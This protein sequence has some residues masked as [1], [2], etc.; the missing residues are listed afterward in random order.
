MTLK[1]KVLSVVAAFALVLGASVPAASALTTSELIDLLVSLGIIP[2]DQA[3]A[4]QAAVGGASSTGGSSCA[5]ASAPDMTVGSQG[6]N[7][8][9]LQNYLIGMGY[10]VP[11][12]ATGYF[13][14]QTQSALASYQAAMGISPAAGYFGPVTKASISCSDDSSD[15]ESNDTVVEG[16]GSGEATVKNFDL[17]DDQDEVAEGNSETVAVIEFDSFN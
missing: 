15:D 8:T 11:A 1:S 4:A 9:A 13:G 16:L 7:V 2:A 6:A 14:S 12:G 10:S 3:S 17:N 5:L